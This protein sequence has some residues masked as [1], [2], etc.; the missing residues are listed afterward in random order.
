MTDRM[1]DPFETLVCWIAV[2]TG[3]GVCIA[4][5]AFLRRAVRRRI[6]R[7]L[8][9]TVI[10][11]ALI[12]LLGYVPLAVALGFRWLASLGRHEILNGDGGNDGNLVGVAVMGALAATG[13][14][15]VFGLIMLIQARSGSG[16]PD[17]RSSA[18]DH[19]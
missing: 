5:G 2:L 19:E 10:H 1:K 3:L 14:A 9:A 12:P 7:R 15:L 11:G 18:N 17:R 16:G 4:V 13:A 8:P 6:L